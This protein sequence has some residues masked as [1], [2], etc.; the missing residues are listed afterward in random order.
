[1]LSRWH[2]PTERDPTDREDAGPKTRERVEK[3]N[4]MPEFVCTSIKNVAA[5]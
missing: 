3:K 1:M 2:D 5:E 4:T